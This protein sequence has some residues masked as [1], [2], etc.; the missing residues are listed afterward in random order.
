[1]QTTSVMLD[2]DI[3]YKTGINATIIRSSHV[4]DLHARGRLVVEFFKHIIIQIS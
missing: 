3:L 4:L 1:M 2:K